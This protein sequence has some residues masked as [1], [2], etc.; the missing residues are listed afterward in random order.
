M[1]DGGTR[2]LCEQRSMPSDC[3]QKLTMCPER[4]DTDHRK[5]GLNQQQEQEKEKFTNVFTRCQQYRLQNCD[6][7]MILIL[8]DSEPSV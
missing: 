4:G 6:V 3:L 5:E 2:P 7:T 8:A 1:D